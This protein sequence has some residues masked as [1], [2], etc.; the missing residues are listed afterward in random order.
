MNNFFWYPL[1]AF[2]V[3][4]PGMVATFFGNNQFWK[5][6]H[7]LN[8]ISLFF[9]YS[10][11]STFIIKI[12]PRGKNDKI[13]KIV[14]IFFLILIVLLLF[15]D[16]LK[17]I[18]GPAFAIANLGLTVFC[19]TYYYYIFNTPP[20]LQLRDEPSFWIITGIF[21]CMT[22]HIPMYATYNYLHGRISSSTFILFGSISAFS[23]TIMHLFF[24]K[25][26]ICSAHLQHQ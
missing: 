18:N 14:F 11:L 5:P 25:A 26:Y 20:V 1:L 16:D 10:F 23:Y 4:L 15:T 7:L 2:I 24:I 21:F 8:N 3:A 9:H 17:K 13:L 22:L 6:A 12:L 19:M